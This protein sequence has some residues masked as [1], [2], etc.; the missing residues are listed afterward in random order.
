MMLQVENLRKSFGTVRAVGGIGFSVKKGEVV[1][2][3]GPNGA[4][5]TTTMRL[6]T[7]FLRPESGTI[8][9][10]EI[11]VLEKSI[12]AR[13][14]IGY[15]PENAPL[16][17]DMEVTEF[18]AYAMRLRKIDP[19]QQ[20]GHLKTAIE[21]CAL[22]EVVG[23]PI[24]ELSRGFRQRVGLAQ[25]LIHQPP[26]LILD[27]PTSGLDPHQIQE[28]R[29]LIKEIGKERTV[30]LSTHIMQEV[31]AVC[32][33]VL[34]MAKGKLVGEGTLAELTKMGKGLSRY[35]AKIKAS[36][37]EIEQNV[38]KLSELNLAEIQG[39]SNGT[40]ASVVLTS[41][42]TEDKCEA[43]FQWV[44]KNNWSLGELRREATSLEEIFLE[45]TKQ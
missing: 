10:N 24:G 30:I 9:V 3:L 22:K 25:A 7:G 20:P 6:V 14:H 5:K 42:R 40:W 4:G 45:L 12:E 26:L 17:H 23:R 28:I 34:I 35:F 33:R 29:N 32:Q 13:R 38:G 37:K 43:I 41:E 39:A 21:R 44:V 16:Y 18:L 11:P 15:L 2:L 1:G 31:E 27:E 8:T 36:P 19:K